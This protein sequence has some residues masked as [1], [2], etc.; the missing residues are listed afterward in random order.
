MKCPLSLCRRAFASPDATHLSRLDAQRGGSHLTTHDRV[1]DALDAR[2]PREQSHD[3]FARQLKIVAR[4]QSLAPFLRLA[5][6]LAWSGL[7]PKDAM[8]LAPL[9][10]FGTTD[11]SRVERDALCR[12]WMFASNHELL[13]YSTRLDQTRKVLSFRRARSIARTRRL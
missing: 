12:Q 8:K 9:P 2:D 10:A 13:R 3:A 6:R 1:V 11:R 7:P 5:H 4:S